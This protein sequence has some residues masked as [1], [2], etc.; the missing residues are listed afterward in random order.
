MSNRDRTVPTELDRL[1]L[2]LDL[3]EH[4]IAVC[5]Q[6][7]LGE[8]GK[9][10]ISLRDE[11]LSVAFEMRLMLLRKFIDGSNVDLEKVAKA[12]GSCYSGPANMLKE[13]LES[14]ADDIERTLQGEIGFS[15][16]GMPPT[17]HMDYFYNA[18]YGR[19]MHADWNRWNL[20][21][22]RAG[23]E[24]R[25]SLMETYRRLDHFVR[26]AHHSVKSAF[27][28]GELQGSPE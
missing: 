25:M 7:P 14:Y 12:F 17:V 20:L 10:K 8:A 24:V 4:Y 2:F 18:L 11:P 27:D 1:K 16:V 9:V 28:M 3:A 13:N 26:E 21:Q 22:K 6:L 15:I 19:L 5:E 23:F